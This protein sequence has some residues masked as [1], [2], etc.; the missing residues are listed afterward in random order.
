MRVVA[1]VIVVLHGLRLYCQIPSGS[2]RRHRWRDDD[3]W[4]SLPFCGGVRDFR[5]CVCDPADPLKSTM[6][7]NEAMVIAA[8][9]S[10]YGFLN[11]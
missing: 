1:D 11:G 5:P 8:Y 10:V 9:A 7:G 4:I 2:T 6:R 3:A